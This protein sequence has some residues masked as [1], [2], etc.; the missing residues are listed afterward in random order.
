LIWFVLSVAFAA[1]PSEVADAVAVGNCAAVVKALPAPDEDDERLAAGHCLRKLGK[2]QEAADVLAKVAGPGVLSDYARYERAVALADAGKPEDAITVVKDLKLPGEHGVNLRMLRN[3]LLVQAKRSLEARDDLRLLLETDLRDEARW[4]LSVGAEDRGDK[5]AAAQTYRKLWAESVVGPWSQQAAE[6]LAALGSPVPDYSTSDGRTLV[7]DRVAALR[8]ANRHEDALK[9]LVEL[10]KVE[11]AT[12]TDAKLQMARTRFDARDY[13]GARDAYKEV[14]GPPETCTGSSKDLFEY[15][16]TT[17]RAGDYPTAAVIYKRVDAQHPDS[18]DADFASFKLGYMHYDKGQLEDAR[19]ELAAHAARRPDSKH[20][21]EAY[22]FAGRAAWRLGDHAAAVKDWDALLQKRPDSSLAP[23]AL[24]WKARAKG[25]AGDA[26]GEKAGLEDLL[27]R[28]PVSGHAWFAA[29]RLGRTFE[30]KERVAR[31]AWP[32]SFASRDD[33][34]RAEAL[35]AVGFK[36]EARA[37]LAGVASAAKAGG[38]ESALAAAHA[39]VAAGDYKGGKALAQP[40]CASPWKGGDAVAQQACTPMP[41]AS[42]VHATAGRYGLD[43]LVPFG[44]MTAESG[45]DPDVTSIAGARGLMQLMPAE[46]SRI[47]AEA[48]GQ[49]VADPDD[50]YAAPYNAAIGTTELGM[51]HKSLGAVLDGTSLPAVIA[52]YNGGEEAVRR[53]LTAYPQK[54]PFDEFAEDVGYTETRQYVRRVLGYV[55]AYRWVY[56]DP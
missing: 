17:A 16:L 35:L 25:L 41:E 52:S 4:W 53:W 21:D 36:R 47:H 13:A 39:L 18:V 55:M 44:I 33:V 34:K 11:P 10:R 50:L 9:L 31:P 24:Y 26:A 49:S 40:Y 20:L 29:Y 46:L 3:R 28:Y 22:W 37:E 32:A 12:T 38:K 1:V 43:P 48:F 42:I 45:L 5:D 27:K 14:L 56:G 51:K 19:K 30:K 23:G 15:A 2:S 6:R 7:K 54:P 8:K